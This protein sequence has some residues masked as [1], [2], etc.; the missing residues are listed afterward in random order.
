MTSADDK[1]TVTLAHRRFVHIYI[2]TV[3][4]VFLGLMAAVFTRLPTEPEPMPLTLEEE[5]IV[6]IIEE[7]RDNEI[8]SVSVTV[9]EIAS[10]VP[11]AEN[12]AWKANAAPVVPSSAMEQKRP[13][14]AIIIDDLG[15]DLSATRRIAT[16]PGPLTMA[17]LPY[18][19]DLQ[20]Q[21]QAALRAGHELM[22]HLPMQSQRD[23]ADPGNNA[24][25]KNLSFDEFGRRIE[26][27]LGRFTGFVGVN[28]HM[29][30]LLTED[31]ALMVRLMA[32]LRSDGLLFVDSLTTPKS[33]GHRAAKALGVPFVARDIFLDNEQN[34]AYILR[35]L[36]STEKIARIRGYAIAIGHP[37]AVT[38]DTLEE[39]RETLDFKGLQLVAI[40][41]VM[42]DAMARENAAQSR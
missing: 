28:N 7:Y 25:L 40:S 22:V 38:L 3:L 26:W 5:D 34:K 2:A 16:I 33:M 36:A 23:T 39:W 21:T 12:P 17:F 14:I 42:N 1:E 41:D 6:A 35:Q 31:P 32:R 37:H 19:D 9:D 10:V 4:L 24:L 30:S 8:A 29:G 20:A 13:K 15:L 27:N 18:A 11:V